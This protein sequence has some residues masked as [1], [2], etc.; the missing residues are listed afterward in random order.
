M[1]QREWCQSHQSPSSKHIFLPETQR[2]SNWTRLAGEYSQEEEDVFKKA[3]PSSH[4]I[5]SDL[6]LL[7]DTASRMRDRETWLSLFLSLYTVA[8]VGQI[9]CLT[10]IWI[11]V[12]PCHRNFPPKIVT[13]PCSFQIKK[14]T[15]P[16]FLGEQSI[17][18]PPDLGSR[19]PKGQWLHDS[20]ATLTG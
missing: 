15:L 5:S 19:D 14:K 16:F 7:W 13:L 10:N 20:M 9:P 8:W 2:I 6:N 12:H 18:K 17:I 4:P 11:F 3:V 1:D